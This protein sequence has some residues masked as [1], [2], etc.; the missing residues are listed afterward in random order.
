M[1]MT[2]LARPNHPARLL[3]LFAATL[4]AFGIVAAAVYSGAYVWRDLT[5]GSDTGHGVVDKPGV[6]APNGLVVLIPVDDAGAFKDATG[7]APFVPQSLPDGT[8]ATP[9]FAV[10]E[11]DANGKRLGRVGFSAKRGYEHEG[12]GG[13]VVIISEGQGKPGAG[14]DATVRPLGAGRALQSA[15]ACRDLVLDVQL[16]FSPDVASGEVAITPYMQQTA[17]SFVASLHTQCDN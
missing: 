16:Y 9:K 3:A 13:P 5:A 14:I 1:T 10:T 7:F 12:I 11:P 17:E 6:E 4:A 2:V 8:D 15:F